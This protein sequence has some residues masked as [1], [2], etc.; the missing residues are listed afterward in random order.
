[1]VLCCAVCR[2]VEVN[3]QQPVGGSRKPAC[4]SQQ[5]EDGGQQATASCF[6]LNVLHSQPARENRQANQPLNASALIIF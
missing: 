4:E 3:R 1:M 2:I 6:V 5:V